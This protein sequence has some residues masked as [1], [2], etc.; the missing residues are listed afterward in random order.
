MENEHRKKKCERDQE[1]PVE[2]FSRAKRISARRNGREGHIRGALRKPA[3]RVAQF[4]LALGIDRQGAEKRQNEKRPEEN[5]GGI[6]AGRAKRSEE[7]RV[8]KECRRRWA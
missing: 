8:G 5:G 3:P 2:I 1:T 4:A 6:I 7:R